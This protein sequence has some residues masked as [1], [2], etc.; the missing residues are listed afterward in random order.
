MKK[1]YIVAIDYRATYKPM[2]TDYKVLEAD[3]LLDAMSEAESYLDTE[4]VYLLIIMQADKAGHKVKGMPG[5]RENTYIE[6][7]SMR[8][9]FISGFLLSVLRFHLANSPQCPLLTLA[10]LT[11]SARGRLGNPCLGRRE[12]RVRAQILD[13]HIE[14]AAA[15][16][17]LVIVVLLQ[18]PVVCFGAVLQDQLDFITRI[19]RNRND[20]FAIC[21]GFIRH[22]I[23][24][25]SNG[26]KAILRKTRRD[27]NAHGAQNVFRGVNGYI[28]THLAVLLSQ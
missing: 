25:R 8:F 9:I 22:A 10:G 21:T 2:T 15:R 17:L 24:L 11:V 23:T 16:G 7:I 28:S 13:L 1:S 5:I 20:H 6:Q 3:N 18:Q 27:V 14:K 12:I 19:I 26:N 4:K